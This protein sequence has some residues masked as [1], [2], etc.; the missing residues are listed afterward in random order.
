MP[1]NRAE[2]RRKTKRVWV[3]QG[4]DDEFW[5][6]YRP[7]VMTTEF[8]R[9]LQRQAGVVSGQIPDREQASRGMDIIEVLARNMIEV[10]ADWDI[11][12]DGEK[13]PVTA[14]ELIS[15]DVPLMLNILEAVMA[16]QDVEPGEGQRTSNVTSLQEAMSERSLPGTGSFEQPTTSDL[17]RST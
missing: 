9:E 3:F 5:I 1:L 10:I 7:S 2:R 11:N 6:D 4:T 12:D 16:G 13:V 17:I 14:E 15:M 8:Y